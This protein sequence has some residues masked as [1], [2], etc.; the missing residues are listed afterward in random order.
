MS[1]SRAVCPTCLSVILSFKRSS[2][3]FGEDA[4]PASC[5]S[6]AIII[7]KNRRNNQISFLSC[8]WC[9]WCGGKTKCICSQDTSKHR[10]NS[11]VSC[12]FYSSTKPEAEERTSHA[13]HLSHRNA[14]GVEMTLIPSLFLSQ[15]FL[16]SLVSPWKSVRDV[17]VLLHRQHSL[18][19]QLVI[20]VLLTIPNI[21]FD[22]YA[23]YSLCERLHWQERK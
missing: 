20:E 15:V 2:L 9:Y 16:Y 18:H 11:R 21:H 4:A 1:F 3:F 10:E 23:L 19:Q 22:E 7:R 5:P 14:L 12:F 8:C 6:L 13:M 17:L